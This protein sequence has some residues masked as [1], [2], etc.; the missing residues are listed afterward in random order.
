MTPILYK[1]IDYVTAR[2]ITEI[3][4]PF[5]YAAREFLKVGGVQYRIEE[6]AH[7]YDVGLFHTLSVKEV[8]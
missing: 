8:K 7:T 6:V 1:V 2:P 5:P 3:Q 4:A